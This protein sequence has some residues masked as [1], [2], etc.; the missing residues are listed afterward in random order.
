M[1]PSGIRLGIS[2]HSYWELARALAV[3]P[4]YIPLGPI[5][6]TTSKTIPLAPQGVQRVEQWSRLLG[7]AYSLVAIGGIGQ[8]HAKQLHKTGVG[9]VAM[10]LAITKANDYKKATRDLL[11]LWR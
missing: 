8:Q 5:F 2:T 10:I 6:E 3:N 9:S 11:Q 1:E 4:S 7:D